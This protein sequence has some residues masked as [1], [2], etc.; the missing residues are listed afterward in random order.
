MVQKSQKQKKL[1]LEEYL[2]SKY[3]YTPYIAEIAVMLPPTQTLILCNLINKLDGYNK[4]V[5]VKKHEG[6]DFHFSYTQETIFEKELGLAK[7]TFRDNLEKLSEY[8]TFFK[9][10]PGNKSGYTTTFFYLKLDVIRSL[11]NEGRKKLGKETKMPENEN[12]QA[13]KP[14]QQNEYNSNKGTS[15][16]YP[17]LVIKSLNTINENYIKYLNSTISEREYKNILNPTKGLIQQNG[18]KIKENKE[19]KNGY[20]YE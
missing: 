2:K 9:G 10:M 12:K 15:K 19:L 3:T 18:Y 7:Q 11:F 13:N 5:E 17:D 1:R 4:K 20:Y 16:K 8:V 6:K 14:Q